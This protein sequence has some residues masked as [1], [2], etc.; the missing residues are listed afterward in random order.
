MRWKYRLTN[1]RLSLMPSSARPKRVDEPRS[2]ASWPSAESKTSDTMNSTKPITSIQRSWY[3]NRCPATRPMRSDHRVT[4]SGEIPVGYSARAIR[5]PMGRKN[6]RSSHSST[7]CPLSDRSFCGFTEH[8]LQD[9][10][11]RHRLV[12]GDHERGVDAHL[13][14]VDHR[15]HP[16]REQGVEDPPRGLLGEQLPRP[17]DDE[18]H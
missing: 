4:W 5:I 17:R 2:R 8:L 12:L 1:R 16:A 15:E 13:G 11:G 14:V 18:I 10:E 9:R 6:R 7:A 3:T